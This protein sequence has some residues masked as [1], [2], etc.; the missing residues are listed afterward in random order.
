MADQENSVRLT[1]AARKRAALGNAEE[2][3]PNKKRVVL[4]ELSNLPNVVVSRNPISKS[5]PQ[6]PKGK[7]KTKVKKALLPTS[8]KNDDVEGKVDTDAKS[9]DPQMCGPYV[10]DIYEYL[11]TME[12]TEDFRSFWFIF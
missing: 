7:A 1:R 2:Q 11:H 4:G 10:S 5:E 8:T 12:V 3:P 9:D 6:K